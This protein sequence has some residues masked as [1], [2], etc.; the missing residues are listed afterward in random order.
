[1]VAR[2]PWRDRVTGFKVRGL[3]NI[4]NDRPLLSTPWEG[5]D[6]GNTHPA[7]FGRYS[8][9]RELGKGGMAC[10]YEGRH[11]QLGSRVALKV[12]NAAL[13]A[14]PLAAT[15]FLREAK[16]SAQIRHENVVEV[17]DIGTQDGVPF[18][19]MEFVEGSDLAALLAERGALPPSGIVD[20]F[21]PVISAIA[22]AHQAGIIHRDLK[23]A[24]LMLARRPPRGVHPMVLD[25]GISKIMN[26]EGVETVTRSESL[27]PTVQY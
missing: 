21:L 5:N 6:G 26:D 18:I 8:V 10:V 16:A 17:F 4:M 15:R 1:M 11:P 19:V 9:V 7:Q 13:A 3:R 24:N 25:F 2:E 20:I 23:P 14:Q 22:M 27:T 12:M